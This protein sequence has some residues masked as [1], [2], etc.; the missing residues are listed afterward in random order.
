M[1][2]KEMF[3]IGANYCC[4]QLALCLHTGFLHSLYT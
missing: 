1:I 3:E 4:Q 2:Q